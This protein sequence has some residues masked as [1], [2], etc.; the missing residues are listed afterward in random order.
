MK[1]D[2]LQGIIERDQIVFQKCRTRGIPVFMVTSG[3]YLRET[4]RIVADSI[5]NLREM[6]LISCEEAENAPLVE[7]PSKVLLVLINNF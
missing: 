2:G 3:G 6:G 7:T 5:L 4:A 1:L